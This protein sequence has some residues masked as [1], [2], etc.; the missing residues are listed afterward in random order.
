MVQT[1]RQIQHTIDQLQA[2]TVTL[3]EELQALYQSYFDVLGAAC[4]RQ[5]VLAAYHICTQVYPEAFLKLSYSQ[6]EKF[7]KTLQ[8]LGGQVYE[9]L[10]ERWQQAQQASQK[11]LPQ[12][13]LALIKQLFLQ[14]EAKAAES[15]PRNGSDASPPEPHQ[16]DQA[17]EEAAED[18]AG[19]GHEGEEPS[20]PHYRILKVQETDAGTD[21]AFLDEN[22]PERSERAS[23]R[24]RILAR[25]KHPPEESSADAQRSDKAT[26]ASE[27]NIKQPHSETTD[28]LPAP[29]S[30]A[31]DG[32]AHAEID[33]DISGDTGRDTEDDKGGDRPRAASHPK[34]TEPTQLLRLQLFTEKSIRDILRT[35]SETANYL[36][37]QEEISPEMPK[38][39]LAAAAE[40]DGLSQTPMKTPNLLKISVRILHGRDDEETLDDDGDDD[41]TEASP[42]TDA[43]FEEALGRQLERALK[44]RNHRNR[45]N[46][47]G[48][49]ASVEDAPSLDDDS[50]E[51]APRPSD[52]AESEPKLPR[53]LQIESLPEFIVIHLRLSEIE[54]ADP[55]TAACRR[56]I[57]AKMTELKRLGRAYK[58]AQR[59]LAIAQAEDAWRAS[60]ID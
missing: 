51:E 32:D 26:S 23:L 40:S 45:T 31:D 42:L 20:Q 38:A 60:W 24:D 17:E 49:S 54:F 28:T 30:P 59:Q 27:T 36:L 16:N 21:I 43:M 56:Q 57:R 50:D 10:Q 46:D 13:G 39:L 22:T 52:A 58:K 5:L 14:A 4:Q 1:S 25:L 9:Q 48:T 47:S 8:Q 37:Q 2:K 12:D 3:G 15:V 53:I 7:Q 34:L 35:I 44:E 33:G 11:S 6:R 18:P 41:D 55:R 19:K 29:V